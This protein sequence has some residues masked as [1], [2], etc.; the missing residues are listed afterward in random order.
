MSTLKELERQWPWRRPA[1]RRSRVGLRDG[2]ALR[3][4][5][6]KT[7]ISSAKTMTIRL[8]PQRSCMRLL[9]HDLVDVVGAEAPCLEGVRPPCARRR[10]NAEPPHHASVSHDEDRERGPA[11]C[12]ATLAAIPFWPSAGRGQKTQGGADGDVG[13]QPPQQAQPGAARPFW[14]WRAHGGSPGHLGG[15]PRPIAPPA[16]AAADASRGGFVTRP[17]TTLPSS[18]AHAQ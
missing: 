11:T 12:S 4:A 16:A 5:G 15:A 3:G 6:C 9:A 18:R 10:G 1:R 8:V 17:W 13:S 14:R 2:D 7:T